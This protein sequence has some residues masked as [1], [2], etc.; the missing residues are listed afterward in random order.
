MNN[1]IQ[2]LKLKISD[3]HANNKTTT[4]KPN[5]QQHDLHFSNK[6]AFSKHMVNKLF[7]Q[8]QKQHMAKMTK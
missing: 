4:N 5:S 7:T 1:T 3:K 2:D 6:K 8:I